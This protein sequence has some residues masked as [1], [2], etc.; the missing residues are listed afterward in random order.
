M[1]LVAAARAILDG[2]GAFAI[3]LA[4]LAVATFA[5]AAWTFLRVRELKLRFDAGGARDVTRALRL[6]AS[7]AAAAP[8]VGLLGTVHGL[9]VLFS[10]MEG[11]ASFDRDLMARGVG[12]AL[13]TTEFGLAIAVPAL[14]LHAML[15]R[16]LRVHGE[17]VGS[18]RGGR[19]RRRR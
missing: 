13:F 11:G 15:T 3:P 8:L 10:G 14:V 18:A 1:N 6:L 9:I 17:A 2:A 19:R 5:L 12:Q 7:A 4:A 16:V